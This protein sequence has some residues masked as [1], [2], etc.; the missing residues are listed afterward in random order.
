M[1]EMVENSLPCILM[2][3]PIAHCATSYFHCQ[4]LFLLQRQH[5]QVCARTYTQTHAHMHAYPTMQTH[6]HKDFHVCVA[7]LQIP[8]RHKIEV[9]PTGCIR[10]NS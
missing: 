4:A 9:F 8:Q 10:T 2:M 1:K 6:T 7:L 5:T 3:D